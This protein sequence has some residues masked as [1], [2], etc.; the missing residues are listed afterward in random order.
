M[1]DSK[2]CFITISN[3]YYEMKIIILS[4]YIEEKI[5]IRY[6][7]INIKNYYFFSL[8]KEFMLSLYNEMIALAGISAIEGED[9]YGS[10]IIFCYPNSTDFIINLT[11]YN[12]NTTN[13]LIKFYEKCKIENNI[14]GHIFAGIQI[15]SFSNVLK[16]IR[17]D[18][19]NE[20]SENILIPNNTNV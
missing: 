17:E 12:N 7:L 5:K 13:P 6:Y 3:D 16:L 1:E 9:R 8:S 2:F 4:N 18:N 20:I 11:D 19:K 10:I 15:I 14:F